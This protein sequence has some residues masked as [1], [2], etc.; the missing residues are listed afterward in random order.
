MELK[1]LKDIKNTEEET[2][3]ICSCGSTKESHG[4]EWI[5]E[6]TIRE[7]AIKWVKKDIKDW[8]AGGLFQSEIIRRWKERFNITEED[9]K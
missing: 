8:N 9:L 4:L 7:E 2:N 3:R 6:S 5:R 1:T